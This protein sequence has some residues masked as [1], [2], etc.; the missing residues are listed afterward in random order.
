MTASMHHTVEELARF[1]QAQRLAYDCAETIAGEMR[2]GMTERQVAARMKTYLLDHGADDC[3]HQPFAWFG[4]RTAFR[5]LIALKQLKGFNPAFYPGFRRLEENMPFI[6]DCAPTLRGCTADIGY[7]G[8]LGESPEL[9]RLMDDLLQYRRLILTMAK[10]RKP[11]AEISRAVDALCAKHGYDPRH[12]AYPFETL[13]HRIE[14]LPDDS[15]PSHLAIAR[16]GVRNVSELVRDFVQGSREGWSPIWNSSEASNHP[17]TPGLWAVEPHLGLKGVGAKWEEL[18]VVT[19]DDAWW[20]D[21]DVPHVRRWKA[22]GVW[23]A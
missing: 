1:R 18:L 4:D 15:R 19:E 16:F 5:G 7:C 14:K 21:D 23:P 20:L 3:F 11:L 2:P 8:V 10:Q 13:A 12:K 6:L 22:R 17:P 9:D